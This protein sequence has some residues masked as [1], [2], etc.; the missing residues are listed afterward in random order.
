MTADPAAATG[1][2]RRVLW[3]IKGLGP[4]GSERLLTAAAASHDPDAYDLA[5]V[6][7]VPEADELASE[8]EALGVPCTCLDVHDE[9]DLRW[10]LRLRRR[11][12]DHPVDVL[13]MHSPYAAGF[14]RLAA[15]TLPRRLWPRLVTT[16]H[17]GWSTYR[18]PTW[19]VN[20]ASGPLDDAVITVSDQVR[21]SL[22]KGRRRSAVTVA[23]GVPVDSIRGGLADRDAVRHELGVDEQT[24]LF[25]TVANYHR[26][27]DWPTLL[28]AAR[29]IV[30]SGAK[31]RFC[32]VGQG[33]LEDE[34][35]ELHRSLAL[36]DAV[37]L[38]G[39]RA[40]AVHLMAG[41]DGFVLSTKWEGMPVAL[42]EACALGLPIVAT[43]AGGI[44]EHFTDGIDALLVAPERPDDL[45]AAL[46]RIV[47]D[48]CMRDRLA[49]ASAAHSRIFDARPSVAR[50]EAIYDD[51]L[52]GR[53][54][55]RG[56][57]PRP[58]PAT[59]GATS[60]GVVR[61]GTLGDVPAVARLHSEGIPQGFLV[62]L[63][64]RF[65]ARLYRRVIRSDRAFLL[66]TADDLG[67]TGF[68]AVTEDTHD[69][70]REFLV[71]DGAPA[72]AAA[73]PAVARAPRHVWETL[74]YG[75]AGTGEGD[76]TGRGAL[77]PAEILTVA[78]A[79]RA[80]GH[81]LGSRLVAGATAELAARGIHAA[82]VVTASGNE[83]ALRMYEKA[84]FARVH[85]TE[86]H[87]GT[88]QEVLVWP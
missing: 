87:R 43:A 30:D 46:L 63:G 25:G 23:H 17:N 70:Y 7:L 53:R 73:A 29:I 2:R 66:V 19:A 32:A 81:G 50:I 27:K 72:A 82:R 20:A 47:D 8:L 54:S 10:V 49:A 75:T 61:A 76:G 11:L 37:I 59:A 22:P 15:R 26:K 31:V 85:T 39:Y 57:D 40:D 86:L 69:F 14:A 88:R 41:V 3:L 45:A 83:A 68:V 62:T 13:H 44:P 18:R 78:V 80:Q 48:P 58:E 35:R 67:I 12:R 84:G 51:V 64:Q 71:R 79:P 74:H 36:G 55:T 16:E 21:D 77:P 38:T 28:R 60:A 42:M 24:F 4:G 34:V 6:Y 9:L 5:V 1:P 52:A 33:P 56:P 65:L